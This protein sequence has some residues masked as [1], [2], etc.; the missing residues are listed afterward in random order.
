MKLYQLWDPTVQFQTRSGKNLVNGTVKVT[1]LDRT[2][3]APVYD[4]NGKA[5]QNPITLDENGRASVYV[6]IN[7]L[8]T[9]HVYD[10]DGQ[11]IYTQN[12]REYP[13]DV[14]VT[15]PTIVSTDSIEATLASD[16]YSL[17]V[18]DEY[19]KKI[20]G[21]VQ[22]VTYDVT[23]WS[24]IDF[25]KQL[26]L[27]YIY[28]DTVVSSAA[29]TVT[30]T[31]LK[32]YVDIEN[33]VYVVQLLHDSNAWSATKV[34][35]SSVYEA[36]WGLP[37]QLLNSVPPNVL[38]YTKNDDA[39]YMNSY[40]SNGEWRFTQIDG[41][42]INEAK[43]VAQGWIENTYP[44]G[45]GGSTTTSRIFVTSNS[46]AYSCNGK[47]IVTISGVSKGNTGMQKFTY[48]G[49]DY[50]VFFEYF[51]FTQL[52]V[53][54]NLVSGQVYSKSCKCYNP[55]SQFEYTPQ[56][57]YGGKLAFIQSGNKVYVSKDDMFGYLIGN[58][59]LANPSAQ[60][61]VLSTPTYYYLQPDPTVQGAF[62]L[63][64]AKSSQIKYYDGS[65]LHEVTSSPNIDNTS[66][67]SMVKEDKIYVVK[68]G[69]NSKLQLVTLTLAANRDIA[70]ST[71]DDIDS[72][73][74]PVDYYKNVLSG[75]S[76]F[77]NCCGWSDGTYIY[78]VLGN[79]AF[80]S[81]MHIALIAKVDPVAKTATIHDGPLTAST[82][83]YKK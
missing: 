29:Y 69:N 39:V 55:N 63:Q 64:T 12:I 44:I 51:D 7:K 53:A 20:A 1:Y 68:Y 43:V 22:V 4:F 27:R 50:V 66:L 23:K 48:T 62:W 75:A 80:S 6:E 40:R 36:T 15:V 24:D 16:T 47:N 71:V 41:D 52:C 61:D 56:F 76:M 34:D 11:L 31:A 54:V 2:D 14:T 78:V 60:F 83:W 25:T 33:E 26:M 30:D 32:F 45:G 72:A 58:N 82:L 35:T 19:I 70:S 59:I 37:L 49:I 17:N 73:S 46:T 77:N 74:I 8:Y 28:H 21:N 5:I 10:L 42:V 3:L 65:T 38:V 13:K 81:G 18:K 67:A 9:I 79:G 57:L